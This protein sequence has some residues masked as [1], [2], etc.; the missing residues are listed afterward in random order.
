MWYQLAPV[1]KDIVKKME[2]KGWGGCVK[3]ENA[4]TLLVEKK[5]V[6]PQWGTT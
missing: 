1:R 2:N 5:L 3:K 6:Q 4:C